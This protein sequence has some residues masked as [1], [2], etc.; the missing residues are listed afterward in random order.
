M[1]KKSEPSY[2]DNLAKQK[3]LLN[4]NN[5]IFKGTI[6]EDK[7]SGRELLK[8]VIDRTNTLQDYLNKIETF[9]KHKNSVFADFLKKNQKISLQKVIPKSNNNYIPTILRELGKKIIPKMRVL[10]DSSINLSDREFPEFNHINPRPY[11]C[12]SFTTSTFRNIYAIN[13]IKYKYCNN[14]YKKIEEFDMENFLLYFENVR[15]AIMSINESKRAVYCAI[16][17]F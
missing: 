12:K 13:V 15:N 5:S 3:N 9:N 11:Q 10:Q 7:I 17:D 1:K 4:T 16:C 2:F 6:Y 14:V 8:S